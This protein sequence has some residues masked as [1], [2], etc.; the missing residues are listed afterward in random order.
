[1]SD[2]DSSDD[3]SEGYSEISVE[4]APPA[5]DIREKKSRKVLRKSRFYFLQSCSM[6]RS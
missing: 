3:E 4:P 1:M 2:N 6:I 5:P